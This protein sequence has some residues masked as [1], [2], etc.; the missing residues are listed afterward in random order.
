V[1][2]QNAA[3]LSKL[4]KLTYGAA[5]FSYRCLTFSTSC[6]QPPILYWLLC[7][8]IADVRHIVRMILQ[9]ILFI[10]CCNEVQVV[11]KMLNKEMR[12]RSFSHWRNRWRMRFAAMKNKTQKSATPPLFYSSNSSCYPKNIYKSFIFNLFQSY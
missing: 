7:W 2:F 9:Y 3:S 5:L 11:V 1:V 10:D 12:H 8:Y 4:P 6:Y